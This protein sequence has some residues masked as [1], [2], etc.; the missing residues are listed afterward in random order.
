MEDARATKNSTTA[1][2]SRR[3]LIAAPAWAVE[4]DIPLKP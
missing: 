3:E 4:Y 2:I 1:R